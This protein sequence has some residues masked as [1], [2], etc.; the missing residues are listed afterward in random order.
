MKR[1]LAA[2]F[3]GLVFAI[4][5]GVSGMTL[6]EKV[7]GFLDFTGDWDPALMFVMGGAV[8][9]YAGLFPLITTRMKSPIFAPK[10]S[11]PT[12]RDLNPRLIGGAA[13][14]GLGWGLGGFC[15]G[16][17]LVSVPTGTTDVFVFMLSMVGGMM[18]F[19]GFDTLQKKSGDKAAELSPSGISR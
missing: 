10:F 2:L 16:P 5:L 4:G 9:V 8:M 15:P 14:F 18:L 3:V 13:L 17:A 7:I 19:K 12:R 6:P 11:I 1:N